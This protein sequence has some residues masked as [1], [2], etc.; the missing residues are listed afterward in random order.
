MK[1]MV[2][3]LAVVFV[4]VI[5]VLV[6]IDKMKENHLTKYVYSDDRITQEYIINGKG[7]HLDWRCYLDGE[8]GFDF[9][10]D[11][12]GKIDE[13]KSIDYRFSTEEWR[14]GKGLK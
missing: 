1:K 6:G 2:I 5:A 4:A 13:V 8:L 11:Y 10:N 14:E 12:T 7:E 3:A 9:E